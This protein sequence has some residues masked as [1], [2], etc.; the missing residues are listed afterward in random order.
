MDVH[1][2]SVDDFVPDFLSA[3]QV[4]ESQVLNSH[5]AFSI[6][7][8]SQQRFTNSNEQ[9]WY[10]DKLKDPLCMKQNASAVIAR[11]KS[12]NAEATVHANLGANDKY[13]NRN[14]NSYDQNAVANFNIT[15]SN[16]A[17]MQAYSP[18]LNNYSTED[19]LKQSVAIPLK[20]S[21]N[22]AVTVGTNQVQFNLS[23]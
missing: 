1:A 13:F 18:K 14:S 8:S 16:Q 10:C 12:D 22:T 20:P 4:S 5:M 11:T 6:P 19:T 9:Y 21:N 17:A 2:F 3:G 7:E 23:Y 15:N